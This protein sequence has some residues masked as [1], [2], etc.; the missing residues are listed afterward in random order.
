VRRFRAGAVTTNLC[1]SKRIWV[2]QSDSLLEDVDEIATSAPLGLFVFWV[3]GLGASGG[4][5]SVN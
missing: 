2:I 1:L 4:P 5:D 3:V